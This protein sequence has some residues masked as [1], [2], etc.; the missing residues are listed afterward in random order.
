MTKKGPVTNS[1]IINSKML[2]KRPLDEQSTSF[3]YF[4]KYYDTNNRIVTV[5]PKDSTTTSSNNATSS[6]SADDVVS[7]TE[8]LEYILTSTAGLSIQK[9]LAW[10]VLLLFLL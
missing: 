2:K 7:G 4:L 6:I 10:K 3:F 5:I 9:Q 8:E 1:N